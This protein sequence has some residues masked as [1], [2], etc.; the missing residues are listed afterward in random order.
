MVMRRV[1]NSLAMAVF[2]LGV[3]VAPAVHHAH[4]DDCGH[5]CSHPHERQD[6]HETPEKH[7]TDHCPICQLACTPIIASAPAVVPMAVG[8]V[9]RDVQVDVATPVICRAHRL[10]FS[11]GPPA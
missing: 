6:S 7:D 9:W 5:T 10:P 11:C 4:L 1:I 3:V 8:D 2:A